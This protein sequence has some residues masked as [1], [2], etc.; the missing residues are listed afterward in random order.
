LC[1]SCEFKLKT[2][3]GWGPRDRRKWRQRMTST[4]A[5][6]RSVIL[7]ENGGSC[8]LCGVL[9]DGSLDSNDPIYP[10][11]DHVVPLASGGTHTEDNARCCCRRCNTR[12]ND[13]SVSEF[14][15]SGKWV[16]AG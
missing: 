15:G 13:L 2:N 8:Y 10:T 6:R 11:V 14:L 7:R 16:Y 9:T 12:K 3:V 5:F 4:S 1:I